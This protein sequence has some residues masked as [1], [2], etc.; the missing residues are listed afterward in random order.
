[1]GFKKGGAQDEGAPSGRYRT[2]FHADLA[3]ADAFGITANELRSWLIAKTRYKSIDIAAY[4]AGQAR[5]GDGIILLHNVRS[6]GDGAQTRHWQL[7]EKN[8]GGYWLSSLV[9]HAPSKPKNPKQ[10]TWFWL[11]VEYVRTA[12]DDE[13]WRPPRAGV[14]GIAR[15]LLAAVDAR[16][17]WAALTPTPTLVRP[18]GVEDLLEILT[19]EERRLPTVVASSRGQTVFDSWRKKVE[20]VTK[21][22]PGVASL[23]ILDPLAETEFNKA[24]GGSFEVRGGAIRTYLPGLDLAIDEDAAR[25]RVLSEPR[26]QENSRRAAQLLSGF[27]RR[28]AADGRLPGPLSKLARTAGLVAPSPPRT[29]PLPEENGETSLE[30]LR[31]EVTSLRQ[32]NDELRELF[33]MVG[34]EEKKLREEVADSQS[35]MLDVTEDL[36]AANEKIAEL[37][38]WVRV[39]RKRLENTGRVAEAY[40]PTEEPTKLPTQL[41]EVLEWLDDLDRVEFTGDIDKVW[42][43]EEKAQSS[44]W[45]QTAWQVVLAFQEYADAVADG[46]FNG[47]F[48]KWCAEP[49]SGVAAVS[50]GKVR[51]D[52]SKTVHTNVKMRR[53]RE[54]PVPP[55]VHFSERIHMWAHICI[56]GGAG[57]SSPRMHFYDD[58]HGTGKIYI[59]YLGPHLDVKST[60]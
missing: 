24:V 4:D 34:D 56:G 55:E 32:E 52:E 58:V 1:M 20:E 29:L 45:A 30:A 60:N 2:V 51:P 28:L 25:H 37:S 49:P 11:D 16:D 31:K 8:D 15:K 5:L 33:E 22:L 27:P 46:K 36:E 43:L 54:L 47:D 23:Y 3:P 19:D 6:G 59:G 50:A 10:R 40:V 35:E 26:I 57:M 41:P 42:K 13:D 53:Q 38:D 9:V 17:H 21:F 39:L 14:P 48:R 7:R 12:D 44:T 18:D